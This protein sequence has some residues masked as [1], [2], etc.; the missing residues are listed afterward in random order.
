MFS[1]RGSHCDYLQWA[2]ESPENTT[3]DTYIYFFSSTLLPN[4]HSDY[5]FPRVGDEVLHTC[6]RKRTFDML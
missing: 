1:V 2:P 6:G 4:T 5:S 3:E